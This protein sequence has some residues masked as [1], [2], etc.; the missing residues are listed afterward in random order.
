MEIKPIR[1]NA[2][3]E[4]ALLEIQRLWGAKEGTREGDRLDVLVTLVDA[5]ESEHFPM[6]P[7]DPIEAIRFRLEQQGL[8]PSALV[9]VIGGRSRVYEVMHRK[10]ALSLE[11][12]RRLNERFGIPADVLIRPIRAGRRR[13]AA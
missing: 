12:I 6:D 9:G 4:R 3:H 8:D 11:M 5:Y 13:R 7:P 10:R 2:D 1:S